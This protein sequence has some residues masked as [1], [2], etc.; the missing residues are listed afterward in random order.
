VPGRPAVGDF[1][2]GDVGRPGTLSYLVLEPVEGLDLA[3]GYDLHAS[4]GQIPHPAVKALPS[5]RRANEEPKADSLNVA[6]DQI[7]S[8]E[9]H[10]GT[11]KLYRATSCLA[12]QA[13]VT[14]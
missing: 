9:A 12:I 4:A 1:D 2:A 13:I 7:V 11:R 8:P 5:G 10:E 14:S 3:L 6:F